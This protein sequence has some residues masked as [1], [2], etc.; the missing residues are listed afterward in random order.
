VSLCT[1][2]DTTTKRTLSVN[3]INDMSMTTSCLPMAKAMISKPLSDVMEG[4]RPVV[5]VP[6]AT[7]IEETTVV[8]PMESGFDVMGVVLGVVLG[9]V[10][11]DFSGM[12]SSTIRLFERMKNRIMLVK[13]Q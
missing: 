7:A 8:V 9:E 10:T 3:N 6:L 4:I 11:S 12:F 5:V 1:D 13:Q 2:P